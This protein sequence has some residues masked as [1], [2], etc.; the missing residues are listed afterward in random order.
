VKILLDTNALIWLIEQKDIRSIGPKTEKLL[1]TAAV[2]YVSP[3]SI[4]E[5]R[6]KTMLGKLTS[7]P[8]LL[9]DISKSG[10]KM[11]DFSAGQ[12]ESIQKFPTLVRHD[13]FDRMLLSQASHE[14]LYLITSDTVLLDLGLDYVTDARR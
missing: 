10:L 7:Q 12:A 9:E 14:G 1:E 8:D 3:I 13:P 11:L 2:V 4:V 6:I 5:I